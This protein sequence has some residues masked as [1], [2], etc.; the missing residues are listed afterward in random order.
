MQI[1]VNALAQGH[2]RDIGAAADPETRRGEDVREHDSAGHAPVADRL[3]SATERQD[4]DLV[5]F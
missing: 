1:V 4:Q 2:P 5:R 3:A